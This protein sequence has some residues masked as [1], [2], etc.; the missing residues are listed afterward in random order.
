[1]SK[2][3]RP[4][5]PGARIFFTVALADRGGDLLVAHVAAL[6]RAVQFTRCQRP[7]GIDAWVVLPD[8]MH[9][10]WNLPEGDCDYATRWRIIK[11]RFSRAVPEGTK[12]GSHITRRERA[13]WQRR[14]WE[15]HIRDEGDWAN[16]VQYCWFNPVKHGLVD[17]PRDWPFSSWHRDNP[18][19]A[20][21]P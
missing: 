10:V 9:C 20:L 2:Y 3:R 5:L 15:H 18:S 7:F 8:H 17:H 21:T 1:M 19:T 13:V 16:H 14:Y 4:A 11:A 6:R 12:R